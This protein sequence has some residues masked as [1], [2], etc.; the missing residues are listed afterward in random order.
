MK[1]LRFLFQILMLALIFSCSS[2]SEVSKSR[3]TPGFYKTK[4]PQG[5]PK[6]RYVLIKN[7]TIWAYPVN[8]DNQVID[9][10][11]AF[12]YAFPKESDKLPAGKYTFNKKTWDFNFQTII[13][14]FRP[15]TANV[16]N[17]L[18]TNFNLNLYLGR[19]AIYTG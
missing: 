14:K 19:R 5:I 7:D 15:A 1:H 11:R 10:A 4:K 17:Q 9:T 18:N 3:L 6:K 12:V 16:P 2:Q 13:F 8:P